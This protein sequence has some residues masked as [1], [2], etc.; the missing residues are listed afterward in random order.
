MPTTMLGLLLLANNYHAKGRDNSH[1]PFA[2][3]VVKE[4]T[5]V[6]HVSRKISAVCSTFLRRGGDLL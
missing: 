5:I 1:D 6:G 4:G 3:A 2:V